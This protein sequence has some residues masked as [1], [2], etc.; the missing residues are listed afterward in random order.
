VTNLREHNVLG[1]RVNPL[2]L[3][4]L[5]AYVTWA[6][7]SGVQRIVAH[8][9]LHSVYLY[10]RDP[11]L[12]R[13]YERADCCHIDGMPLVLAAR[14]AGVSLR[15]LHR[16]TYVDWMPALMEQ[17]TR[18]GWQVA[19]LGSTPEALSRGLNVLRCRYSGLQI[20]GMS[21]YFDA[22]PDSADSATIL[23]WIQENHPQ[24]L[25]VGMGMPRQEHWV[26]ENLSR[27]PVCVILTAGAALDYVAGVTPT[28]PRWSGRWSLEWAFRFLAEPRRLWRRYL[29]EPWGIVLMIALN[30]VAR[31]NRVGTRTGNG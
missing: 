13:F 26:L 19:F 27:L 14:L 10:Q 9:N 15:R 21:G 20:S 4:E 18:S 6:V 16:V 7:E 31:R 28:P 1:V 25:L 5:T 2:S 29:V 30:K 8:H 22:N 11:E 24:L 3:E 12:R 23:H 17:A